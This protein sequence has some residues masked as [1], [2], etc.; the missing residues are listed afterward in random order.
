[1]TPA[2]Y[3][4][5]AMILVFLIGAYKQMRKLWERFFSTHILS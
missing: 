5:S 4:T 1:M 2:G 3:D